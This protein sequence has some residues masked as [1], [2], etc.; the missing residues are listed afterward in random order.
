[1][2]T[3]GG[4]TALWGH[5]TSMVSASPLIG[6]GYTSSRSILPE[7]F[8]W[9]GYAH[10]AVAQTLL[11]LGVLGTVLLWFAL[12]RSLASETLRPSWVAA[13]DDGVRGVAFT[14][15]LFLFAGSFVNE[16]FAGA[17]S[18]EVLMV[19]GCILA[20]DWI[21]SGERARRTLA[22]SVQRHVP[23]PWH[24]RVPVRAAADTMPPG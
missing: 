18:Y 14:V 13:R 19:F 6:Y 22:F 10:N 15:L 16:S 7:A 20:S 23:V 12:L 3:L 17:P 9:A 2:T 24:R 21:L 8:P 4:R 1:M 5:V 11:D